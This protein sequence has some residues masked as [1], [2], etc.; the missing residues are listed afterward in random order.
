MLNFSSK[1]WSQTNQINLSGFSFCHYAYI[2]FRRATNV[3]FFKVII[4]LTNREQYSNVVIGWTVVIHWC[5][6]LAKC[7]SQELKQNSLNNK[8]QWQKKYICILRTINFVALS[9]YIISIDYHWIE[10]KN[11]CQYLFQ[12]NESLFKF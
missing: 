4:L 1:I 2:N 10:K 8:T 6:H 9:N 12:L 11:V 7:L 5:N 3:K